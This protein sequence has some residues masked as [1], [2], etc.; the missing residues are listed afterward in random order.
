MDMSARTRPQRVSDTRRR[1]EQDIDARVATVDPAA[2]GWPRAEFA[3][4]SGHFP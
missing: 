3:V 1:L 2:T 4:E